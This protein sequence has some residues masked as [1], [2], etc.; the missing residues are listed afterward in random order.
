MN[1]EVC[2]FNMDIEALIYAHTFLT[3]GC[4][5]PTRDGAP[6]PNASA[7]AVSSVMLRLEAVHHCDTIRCSQSWMLR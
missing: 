2:L 4:G 7:G 1:V 6:H 5:A 3:L